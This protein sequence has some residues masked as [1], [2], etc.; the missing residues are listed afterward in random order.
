MNRK[1]IVFGR[2][3]AYS[4]WNLTKIIHDWLVNFKKE[5]TSASIDGRSVGTPLDYYPEG[6]ALGS[7]EIEDH[8]KMVEDAWNAWITDLDKMI[9]AFSRENAYEFD[10]EIHKKVEEG[11]E[12]FA[13]K[14]PDLWW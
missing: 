8:D 10:G 5:I 9:F 14:F 11:R 1:G 2:K 7:I 12:L 13:K 4:T 3:D 6:Y